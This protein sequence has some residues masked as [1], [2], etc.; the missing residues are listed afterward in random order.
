MIPQLFLLGF[1]MALLPTPTATAQQGVWKVSGKALTVFP[2]GKDGLSAQGEPWQEDL[3]KVTEGLDPFHTPER[4][5]E[6]LEKTGM[7]AHLASSSLAV[8]QGRDAWSQRG[9]VGAFSTAPRNGRISGIQIIYPDNSSPSVYVGSCQG[10]LWVAQN[11][12]WDGGV[13]EDIGRLLP[14][15]SVRAFAVDPADAQ[16]IIVGTGDHSRYYGSGMYETHDRGNSWLPKPTPSSPS[17]YYRIIYQNRPSSPDHEYVMAATS[18]GLFISANRGG[19]WFCPLY[20]DGTPTNTGLWTDLVEH[21][22]NPSILFACVTGRTNPEMNG[23]YKSVDFGQTWNFL[24]HATLPQGADW[25]RASLA[26]CRTAPDVLAVIV[27]G[28]GSLAGIFKT[29]NGGGSWTNITGSLTGFGSDQI[30]HAQAIAIRPTNPDQIIV[31]AVHIAISNNGGST[32]AVA[33]NSGINW[34]HSDITQL[35]FSEVISENAMWI[36]NDGGIYYHDFTTGGHY[37]FIGGPVT[38]LAC[39]EIDFMDADR[40]VRAIGL[41]DN[42]ILSSINKGQTWLFETGGD[43]AD[44]EIYDPVHGDYFYNSGSYPEEPFWRTFRKPFGGATAYIAN[45]YPV[46]M[47]RLAHQT[48]TGLMVTHDTQSIFTLDAES[49]T[50]WSQ[51]ITDLQAGEYYIRSITSSQSGDG[52]FYVVYWD[53][54]PGDLTVVRELEGQGWTITHR[55]NIM[56]NGQKILSVTPSREWPGESW[57]TLGGLPGQGKIMHT[58]DYGASWLDISNELSSVTAVETLEVQPFNPLVLFAGTNLGMFRSTNGGQ[59]W[60]PF[61]TGLPIGR[62]K[63]LRFVIDPYYAEHSLELAMDGRGMWSMPI[64]SPRIVFVDQDAV[65]SEAGTREHPFHTLAAGIQN[66]SPGS[67]VA[68]RSNTYNE[69]AIYSGDVKVV[70]W[71]GPT[72][73]R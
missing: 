64:V 49:G 67:I 51:I 17:Y 58:V 63:E 23:F 66:G 13:W 59:N 30:T 60:L 24:Y 6:A 12:D 8:P 27:E 2:P 37:S 40:G 39:S 9:P 55:E 29:M 54:N 21:P 14:N 53:N 11:S 36:C 15:P 28:N 65:G 32:W 70:T 42:G 38:G 35:Y 1:L 18:A 52:A 10:G 4:Y 47:P 16:H 22:T 7:N 57:V 48:D 3:R 31:G 44:V 56:G 20:G 69:P 25:G 45:P 19:N 26:I 41:Q 46:Y 71:S 73:I 61:Q 34:G 72:V 5:R 43:G 33:E 50:T 68:V 62:C